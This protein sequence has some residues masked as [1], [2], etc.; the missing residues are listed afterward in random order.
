MDDYDKVLL[1]VHV[2]FFLNVQVYFYSFYVY[3][4]LPRMA[5]HIISIWL[6]NVSILGIAQFKCIHDRLILDNLMYKK[7]FNGHKK[8]FYFY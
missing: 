5:I 3:Q 8:Q 4:W 1:K 6:V 7:I 2:K